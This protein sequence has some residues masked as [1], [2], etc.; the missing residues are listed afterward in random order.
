MKD[1]IKGKVEEA[2]GKMTG[3]KG[4]ELKG[5]AR[6]AADKVRRAGRD[7]RD[8]VHHEADEHR[9]EREAEPV[10]ERRSY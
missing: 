7:I 3:D 8:D 1:Q 9:N 4:E 5:K 10:E 6:Q 2:H